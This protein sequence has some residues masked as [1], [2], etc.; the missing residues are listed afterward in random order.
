MSEKKQI[1][2]VEIS[3]EQYE[4]LRLVA[5]KNGL[6]KTKPAVVEMAVQIACDLIEKGIE[7]DFHRATGLIK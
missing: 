1:Q 7:H 3:E 6:K 2:K 4:T 5:L